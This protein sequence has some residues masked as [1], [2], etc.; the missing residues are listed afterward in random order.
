[1]HFLLDIMILAILAFCAWQ[2]YKRGVIGSILAVAFIIVAVSAANTAATTFSGEFNSMFQPFISGHLDR[3]ERE[4]IEE[5]APEELHRFSTE[6]LFARFPE[7]EP[8]VAR[9]VFIDMGVHGSRAEM[10]TQRYLETR[11]EGLGVNQAM[12]E[13]IVDAFGFYLAY[14]IAFLLILIALTVIYNIIPLSFR[15][16]GL[17]LVDDIGGG[18]LGFVQGLLLVFM[19]TW[20]LG[21]GGILLPDG[22]LSRTWLTEFFIRANPM[23][24][25][26]DL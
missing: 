22:F 10:L 2:G 16:P 15:L 13:V 25:I 18:V 7:I 17:T 21:Y 4:A 12:T 19:L 5:V 1:M 9:Q 6:D 24:G 11:S 20:A 14:I 8:D 23:V 3:V 26:I